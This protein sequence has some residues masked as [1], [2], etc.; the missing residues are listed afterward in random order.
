MPYRN[1]HAFNLNQ[2]VL[3][4]DRPSRVQSH[5]IEMHEFDGDMPIQSPRSEGIDNNANL[6][7]RL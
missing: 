5:C 4:L 1:P 2:Q 3:S 6:K 7:A